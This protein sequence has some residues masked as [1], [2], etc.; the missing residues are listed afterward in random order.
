MKLPRPLTGIIPPMLTPLLDART[1]DGAGTERLVEHVLDGGVHGLFILGTTGEG[2]SLG[3][4]LRRELIAKVCDQ[5]TSRVPV[6]VGITDTAFT[7]AVDLAH[8]AAER[9][10]SAVVVAPPPYFAANQRELLA[11]FSRLAGEIELPMMLYNMPVHTKVSISPATVAA[12]AEI[13][14]VCGLKD[15]S[16]NLTYFHQVQR[17]LR[18][19]PDF[20]LLL[21][22]EELLA[23]SVLMGGHGGVNGGANLFPAL[24]VSL[25]EAARTGD[26]I[27]VRRLQ[28]QVMEVSTQLY[29]VGNSSLSLVQG[30]K[31]ALHRKGICAEALAEPYKPLATD[32]R[33]ELLGRAAAL[34]FTSD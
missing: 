25:F 21:G 1:L 19:R 2:P 20:T 22:P 10:A 3:Y 33:E 9:G 29:S 4:A 6:L 13:E 12:A 7:E 27:G 34:S 18:D 26:L 23:A 8:H 31:A 32:E 30:L 15:S 16:G 14:G 24:Y 28:Q 17:L 11:Y 5:V